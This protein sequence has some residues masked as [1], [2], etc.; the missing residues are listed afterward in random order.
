MGIVRSGPPVELILT[1][2]RQYNIDTFIETG[3]YHGE[4]A[5][6]AASHFN[7]VFTIEYSQ[8]IYEDTLRRLG[9]N[10]N[11]QFFYGDSR[12]ILRQIISALQ[13][14]AVFWLDSHWSGGSTYGIG[15]ECPLLEEISI[16]NHSRLFHFLFIDDAR[17]FLSP[18]PQPHRIDQWPSIDQVITSVT[19]IGRK[20]YITVLD[21]VINVVPDFAKNIVA[22]YC[23]HISTQAWQ[24]YFNK[25]NYTNNQK[26]SCNFE[27]SNFLI[28]LANRGLLTE[29]QP[30]RLHLGCGE[31]YFDGYINI[32]YP[33]SE[34]NVM[35]VK[36]DV[37]A[38]ITE[39]DF[40]FGSVDEIRLHHVFEH[41]N[42]VTALVML[43][44]WQQWLKI[45]GKLWIETPDLIGSAQ[46][47]LSNVSWRTKTG[48]VR[49]LSGDQASA[50]AYHID[51]W[52]PERFEHTLKKFGFD[53]VETY[54]ASWQQEP[55]LS[56]VHVIA[57]KSREL[58]IEELLK[59]AE[60]I[61]WESTVSE[62]EKS[63]YEVWCNQLRA[64]VLDRTTAKGFESPQIDK[65][66]ETSKVLKQP[67]SQL[68]LHKIHNFNQ[69]NRDLWMQ[70]KAE[71]VPSGSRVL[72]IGAGTCPYRSLFSHCDYK[73][74]DFKKYTGEKLGG[75]TEYGTIDYES[76]ITD[77]PVPDSSFDAILCT[78]VLEH[79]QEPFEAIKE[80][81]RILKPGG[82]LILTAPL[83][84]GLHQ[85]PYHFY[86]GYTPEW[87]KLAAEKYNLKIVE[88]RPNGGF[89]KLLAQEC[90]RVAWIFDKHKHLH[91]NDAND[92]YKLF[93][94]LLPRYLFDLDEKCFIDQFTVGYHVEMIKPSP[95]LKVSEEAQ[96]T[97][98]IQNN[99]RDVPS[100]IRLAEIEL[101]RS[102]NKKAQ[103]YLIAAM[104]LEPQNA[105][106]E[107]LWKKLHDTS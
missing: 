13:K 58:I 62:N 70:T 92:I 45:G 23:Q 93:S 87:Y 12:I 55:F 88:I 68:P 38:N 73:T 84:A 66:V 56:N 41:F 42:R 26:K 29:G 101:E 25:M 72:D 24:C 99:F 90:A 48:V 10:Q 74:H 22:T 89:F 20:Y 34:H 44:R 94:E 82:R 63:T 7:N 104:A 43:I 14:P 106:A 6:W 69:H 98:K 4:T 33:P 91:G 75:I 76:D 64:M 79:V 97:E 51:Q 53:P 47:L 107:A 67:D 30:L 103:N 77:I 102:N 46:T 83:G 52:F 65:I 96:L 54:S 3:T 37:F 19:S 40:P 85:L 27:A 15:D 8:A 57:Q 61:L 5:V 35:Q 78:E 1:L 9:N 95:Y 81:A 105:V 71:T 49:H 18:P 39:L 50:W 31:N 28:A 100:F 60:E 36:A 17:L 21:D 59:S 80:M 32:D 86:S 2:A 16:I 11:I